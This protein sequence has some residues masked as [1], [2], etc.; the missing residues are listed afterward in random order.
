MK[1]QSLAYLGSPGFPDVSGIWNGCLIISALIAVFIPLWLTKRA[2]H[3]A[4]PGRIAHSV[5]ALFLLASVCLLGFG[6]V[7]AQPQPPGIVYSVPMIIT[8][9][10]NATTPSSFTQMVTVDFTTYSSYAAPNLQNVEFYTPSGNVIPSWLESGN[11]TS[12]GAVFWLRMGS[13][14]PGKGTI[15][16]GFASPATNLFGSPAVGE[17]PELSTPY[18]Q[19]DNGMQI[20]PFYDNF[21]GSTLGSNWVNNF[22]ASGNPVSV[23]N[24]LVV[25]QPSAQSRLPAVYSTNS[26]A[27]PG[28]LE[29]YTT[30]HA[31]T[32]SFGQGVGLIGPTEA[33]NNGIVMGSFQGPFYGLWTTSGNITSAV[34]GL[35]FNATH[36]YS[37][38]VPSQA[39]SSTVTASVDY[40]SG[41]SSS[42]GIPTVP[43]S[44]AFLNGGNSPS[45]LGPTYWVRVRAYPP[46]G[47]MPTVSFQSSTTSTQT[48]GQTQTQ[49]QTQSGFSISCNPS[50]VNVGSSTQCTAAVANSNGNVPTGTVSWTA[51]S[52]GGFSSAGFT[53]PQCTLSGGMCTV[54]Y[55]ASSGS[56]QVKVMA[57]YSGDS[58][59]GQSTAQFMLN[60]VSSTSMTTTTAETTITITSGGTTS[61]ITTPIT[62]ATATSGTMA[63]STTTTASSV[64]SLPSLPSFSITPLLPLTLMAAVVAVAA[65][66][67]F[68]WVR[69][70]G[71][72]PSR[73]AQAEAGGSQEG[74]S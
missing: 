20:F 12:P 49:T 73:P 66:A 28:I 64:L 55:T 18:G 31:S 34:G 71:A 5:L 30:I 52:P 13:I 56:S 47:V 48:S 1:R 17:A 72:P 58:H 42:R 36:V 14:P 40:G 45:V 60:V 27:A 2:T 59:Y 4:R 54:S 11:S 70:K 35:A 9:T 29:F 41:T 8:N 57:S 61:V 25:G 26:F 10:Q 67:A 44:V 50:S 19:Y 3:A 23:N 53:P 22:A 38:S 37:V 43:L 68:N 24:G 74:S 46:N 69:W 21:R 33:S 32:S 6:Q 16:M 7:S 51:S 63:S 39:P 62:S 65:V 15:L